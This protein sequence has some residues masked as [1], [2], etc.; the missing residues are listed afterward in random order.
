MLR[1]SS[2]S[3][4]ISKQDISDKFP[5]HR[6]LAAWA[7]GEDADWPPFEDDAS[8]SEDDIDQDPRSLLRFD[9]GQHVLCRVGPDP[10]TGWVPGRIIQQWYREAS[11]PAN[12]WA[13]YK[14]ELD[15]G[16]KIFAPGDVDQV[17]RA[18]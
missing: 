9:V 4:H 16:R 11:W 6:V 17:V 8:D 2:E 15:D 3:K 10:V 13:P 18:A 14:V 5:T 1:I 12:S 7:R